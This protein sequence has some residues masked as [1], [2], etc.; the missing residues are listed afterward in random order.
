MQVSKGVSCGGTRVSNL[1]QRIPPHIIRLCKS[2]KCLKALTNDVQH[3]ALMIVQF[4]TGIHI[5]SSNHAS[6]FG[7]LTQMQPR[8]PPGSELEVADLAHSAGMGD[9][10]VLSP[11]G[12]IERKDGFRARSHPYPLPGLPSWFSST[13]IDLSP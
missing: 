1:N 2:K 13:I 9:C 4:K 3:L 11:A 6:S 7:I 8:C 5:G 12:A 10:S